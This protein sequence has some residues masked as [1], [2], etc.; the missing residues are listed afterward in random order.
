MVLTGRCGEDQTSRE[1]REMV[2]MARE[3]EGAWNHVAAK[4]Y[5][6]TS[7]VAFQYFGSQEIGGFAQWPWGAYCT[8]SYDPRFRP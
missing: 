4:E 7:R 8:G 2:C 3:I 5:D 1:A 6:D